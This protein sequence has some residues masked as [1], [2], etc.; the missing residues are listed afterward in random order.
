MKAIVTGGTGYIGSH[1][2]K[3]LLKDNWEVAIIADPKFGYDNILD[4]KN[5]ITIF[6]YT[7]QIQELIKF[8][9][10]FNAG[11]VFHLAAAV[12]TNPSPEQLPIL[13]DSNIRFGTEILEAMSD[14]GTKLIVTTGTYWQNYNGEEY[15]PVDLYA[16]TKEAFEKI[17][18]YYVEA[19][20]IRSIVLRLY[21]VY[22]EDDRRPKIWNLLKG[23]AGTDKSIDMSPGE[24]ILNLVH[25]DDVVSAYISAYN[26]LKQNSE[27]K[28]EVFGVYAETQKTLKE[29]VNELEKT[30]G[31][32]LRINWGA[33]PYKKR[34]VMKPAYLFKNPPNWKCMK[35]VFIN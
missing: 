25:I 29:H 27:I 11:I 34:E 28:S 32:T 6:E 14:S 10:D 13:I 24:Q 8:F 1:L 33:K 12:L 26:Y 23:I 17:L 19:K 18:K 2:V 4:V 3:R 20:G 22:G 5:R 35:L 21:D 31:K 7:G 16:A 30:L 15:N 9:R